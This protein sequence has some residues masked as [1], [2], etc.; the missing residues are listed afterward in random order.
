MTAD[1]IELARTKRKAGHLLT[2]EELERMF[3]QPD[4]S[5][6]QG[7]WT[8][9]SLELLFSSGLRQRANRAGPRPHKPKT[10]RI[11]GAR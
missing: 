3:D 10:A 7:P 11:Y 1:K 4:L 9:L 5:T 8:A 2:E 6:I